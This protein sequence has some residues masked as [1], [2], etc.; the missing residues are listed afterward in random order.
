MCAAAYALAVTEDN[1]M[2]V[3]EKGFEIDYQFLLLRHEEPVGGLHV[4]GAGTKVLGHL[5]AEEAP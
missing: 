4:S 2:K 1:K 3:V 5:V